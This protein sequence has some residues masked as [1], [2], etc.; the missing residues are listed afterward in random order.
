MF[1]AGICT[2]VTCTLLLSCSSSQ[3]SD[4]WKPWMACLAP[5][6]ADLQRD[7]AVGQRGT[8]LHDRAPVARVHLPQRG[9]ACRTRSRGS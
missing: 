7:A 6:Y 5:Q 8:D 3:R 1:T 2:I 4:S 9:H